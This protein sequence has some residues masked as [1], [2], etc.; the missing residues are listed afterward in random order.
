MKS[1]VDQLETDI[2][3]L[4]SDSTILYMTRSSVA[5]DREWALKKVA[6]G[7][8]L[9]KDLKVEHAWSDKNV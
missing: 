6:L 2:R 3:E 4:I 7:E 1:L 5:K 9:H 8:F